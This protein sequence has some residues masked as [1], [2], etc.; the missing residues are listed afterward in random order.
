[1]TRDEHQRKVEENEEE[2]GGTVKKGE[3]S[4]FKPGATVYF[5]P[6]GNSALEGPYLISTVPSAKNY[7]LCDPTDHSVIKN[8]EVIRESKLV[9]G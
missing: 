7:V 8:G 4:R 3:P 5:D 2:R 9:K 1:M 6:G